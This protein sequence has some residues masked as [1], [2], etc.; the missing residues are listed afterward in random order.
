MRNNCGISL[1]NVLHYQAILE[2][3]FTDFLT[4]EHTSEKTRNNY[5]SDLRHFL[6]WAVGTITSRHTSIPQSHIAFIQLITT[7]FVNNYKLYLLSQAAPRST[8]N[9]R[10]STIRIF[11]RCCTKEGWI[12]KNPANSI[13]NILSSPPHRSNDLFETMLLHWKS[14]L[15]REGASKSTIKNYTTDVKQFLEWLEI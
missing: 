9:R 10:L 11:F 6:G 7:D 1:S 12:N 15:E 13:S 2:Q 4:A 3:S 8:I 14:D 5:C